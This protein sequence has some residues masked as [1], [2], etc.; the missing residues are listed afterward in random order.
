MFKQISSII[1]QENSTG[2]SWSCRVTYQNNM[3]GFSYILNLCCHYLSSELMIFQYTNDQTRYNF[4]WPEFIS[5]EVGNFTNYPYLNTTLLIEQ[6]PKR[7]Q[8]RI[9][10]WVAMPGGLSPPGDLPN[11]VIEARSPALQVDSLPSEP[12]GKPMFILHIQYVYGTATACFPH[13]CF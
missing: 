6:Q 13:C 12:P 11:P 8:A 7:V 2:T 4:F 10:E 5:V 1:V 9:L 3:K